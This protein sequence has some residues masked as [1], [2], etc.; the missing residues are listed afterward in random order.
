MVQP[1]RKPKVNL[2]TLYRA[3]A[4]RLVSKKSKAKERIQS[5][6]LDENS[7]PEG[8]MAGLKKLPRDAAH[9]SETRV[10]TRDSD[11]VHETTVHPR[12]PRKR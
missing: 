7:D 4:L 2:V 8:G 11:P 3:E 9:I 12:N 10:H 1:K 6:Q 5:L